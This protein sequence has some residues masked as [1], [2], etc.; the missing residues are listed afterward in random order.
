L[1]GEF[2]VLG[3]LAL[4][5]LDGTLT[6]GH[7]KEVDILVLNRRNRHT[8]KVEVKTTEGRVRGSQLFGAHYS[9]LMSEKHGRIEDK[10][11]VYCFVLLNQSASVTALRRMFLVPAVEVARYVRWN[12]Q[13]WED[14]A[15]PHRG[16]SKSSPLRQFRL[17]AGEGK[18]VVPPSWRDGRWRKWESNWTIF[19][20]EPA[21][22]TE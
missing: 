8:F 11:L 19:E 1:A 22:T 16:A 18:A 7:S 10:D 13:Y 5:R 6:L 15:R 14:Q 17:P 21:N 3:E 20:A 2:F 12:H 4:R 9:W